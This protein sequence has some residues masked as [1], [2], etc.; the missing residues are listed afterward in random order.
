MVKLI[1]GGLAVLAA[2]AYAAWR[3]GEL[4]PEEGDGTQETTIFEDVEEGEPL[5]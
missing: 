5:E 1:A 2:M 3:L 4:E